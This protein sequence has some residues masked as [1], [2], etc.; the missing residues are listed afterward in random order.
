LIKVITGYKQ[1]KGEDIRHLLL[2]LRTSAMQYQGFVS[3][4]NL[5]NEKD[6]SLI[7]LISTWETS[8]YWRLW[9]ESKIK[10]QLQ[11]QI[12]TLLKQKPRVTSYHIMSTRSWK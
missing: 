9:E 2:K 3:A 6:S 5:F 7:I 8:E 1:K 4:E 12:E 11:K 10:Q